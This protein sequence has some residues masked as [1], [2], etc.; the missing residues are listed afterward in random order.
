MP[1][2]AKRAKAITL[3]KGLIEFLIWVSFT[4]QF[5]GPPVVV[6]LLCCYAMRYKLVDTGLLGAGK[7]HA[8]TSFRMQNVAP[9]M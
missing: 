2:N 4:W 8:Q 6:W 1:A 9:T 3:V 7:E 5:A